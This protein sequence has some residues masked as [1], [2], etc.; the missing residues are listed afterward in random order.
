M[1]SLNF[2]VNVVTAWAKRCFEAAP[3]TL[4]HDYQSIFWIVPSETLNYPPSIPTNSRR[5]LT[6]TDLPDAEALALF[7]ER[8]RPTSRPLPDVEA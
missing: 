4:N 2:D 8:V 3:E 6:K 5:S 7:A 1:S